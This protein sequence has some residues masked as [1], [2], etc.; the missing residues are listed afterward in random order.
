V[1]IVKQDNF[2]LKNDQF[3]LVTDWNKTPSGANT[4]FMEGEKKYNING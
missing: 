1:E 2:L 3:L 4:V